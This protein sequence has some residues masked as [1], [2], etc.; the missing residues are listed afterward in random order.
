MNLKIPLD[1]GFSDVFTDARSGERTPT[2]AVRRG[3]RPSP[4]RS[5]GGS[6]LGARTV[7]TATSDR[8]VGLLRE[9]GSNAESAN[10][11]GNRGGRRVRPGSCHLRVG[12][13]TETCWSVRRVRGNPQPADG[14]ARRPST[15]DVFGRQVIHGLRGVDGTSPTGALRC[16]SGRGV[17]NGVVVEEPKE[18]G[19]P[20]LD[21]VRS[22]P[23]APGPMA[24]ATGSA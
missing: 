15:L 18:L 6:G 1:L 20:Q 19:P 8:A 21:S 22:V 23:M 12:R 10:V 7:F 16:T 9:D 24:R 13:E 5:R 3:L 11:T 14:T 2:G 4:H 17:G